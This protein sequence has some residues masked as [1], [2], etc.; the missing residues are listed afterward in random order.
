MHLWVLVLVQLLFTESFC[1]CYVLPTQCYNNYSSAA[2]G[3]SISQPVVGV[4]SSSGRA[5]R[6]AVKIM[7][8]S[9][10][11]ITVPAGQA[12]AVI[13]GETVSCKLNP[14]ACMSL[15]GACCTAFGVTSA[16]LLL[17]KLGAAIMGL[18]WCGWCYRGLLLVSGSLLPAVERRQPGHQW[19]CWGPC[20]KANLRAGDQ[21]LNGSSRCMPEVLCWLI[22]V[23]S[24]LSC[25]S[26]AAAVEL[27][28][29]LRPVVH[30][31]PALLS[32]QCLLLYGG[33]GNILQLGCTA[34]PQQASA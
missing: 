31:L 24:M 3:S 2:L 10:E 5:N 20:G 4:Q 16:V 29:S 34:T 33:T 14:V 15:A 18:R 7:A 9:P 32:S 22:A 1:C 23:G 11:G 21:R 28:R 30:Q 27:I 13:G 19:L 6:R 26:S 8:A 12:V 25:E 17:G